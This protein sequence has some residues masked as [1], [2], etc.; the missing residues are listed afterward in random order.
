MTEKEKAAKGMLYDANYNQELINERNH[1]KEL[2]FKH[3]LLP[4]S[5][6]AERENLIRKI[7]SNIRGSFIIEA[8]FY[9]DLGYNI[10]LGDRFYANYNCIILDGAKVKFG[11]DVFIAPNCGFYAAGHPLDVEQ[12]NAGLEYAYPITVGNNVWIGG[13][14]VVL[15]GVTIGDNTVIGAGSIVTKDIPS[16]VLA[17]GNPCRVIRK[18]TDE[19]KKKYIKQSVKPS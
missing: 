11:D 8:P 5:K 13:N 10:E 19:D 17:Y 18:I 12:R 2:C 16:G 4:P 15:A 7:I 6:I 9:C 14:T 3:N 1:C